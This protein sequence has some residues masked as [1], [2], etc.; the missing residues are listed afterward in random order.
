MD[1]EEERERQKRE[2]EQSILTDALNAQEDARQE[3][4]RKKDAAKPPGNAEK[5]AAPPPL[6]AG[7]VPRREPAPMIPLIPGMREIWKYF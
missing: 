7:F 1:V 3:R 5:A 6:V 4:K 2:A